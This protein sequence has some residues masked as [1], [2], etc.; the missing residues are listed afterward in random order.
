MKVFFTPSVNGS[1]PQIVDISVN[2]IGMHSHQ[3]RSELA[4]RY[5]GLEEGEADAVREQ[6]EKCLRTEPVPCAEDEWTE[7]LECLPPLGWVR[8]GGGE[9]F[10]MSERLSGRMTH[11]Y[12]RYDGRCWTFVDTDDLSHFDIMNRVKLAD[13]GEPVV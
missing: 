5:P 13:Q 3:E 11:I 10:K 1:T 7:A 4:K 8:R 2:G 9:S 12:V 6:I